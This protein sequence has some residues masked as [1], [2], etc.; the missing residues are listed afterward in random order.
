LNEA[1]RPGLLDRAVGLLASA[2][3][4]VGLNGTRLRWR[5][6][7]RRRDL[8]EAGMQA[9]MTVRSARVRYKMCPAC[10]ALVPRETSS[11]TECGAG[12]SRVRAPGVGRALSNVIPGATAATGLLVLLNGVCFLVMLAV[13]FAIPGRETGGLFGFDPGTLLRYGSGFSLLT[14]G[15]GEWWR[16]VTPIF[17][18]GGLLHFAMNT[19]VL[20]QLGPLVEEEY[21]TERFA[22][23]YL[24]TGIASTFG[25]QAFRVVNMVGASGA[26]C[27]LLGLM[28]VHGIRRGGAYGNAIRNVMIQNTLLMLVISF[29]PGIDFVAHLSGFLVGFVLGWVVPYGA[30]RNRVSAFL[31]DLAPIAGVVLIVWAFWRMAVEGAGSALLVLGR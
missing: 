20:L 31:W 15:N 14:F 24:V 4:A 23:I 16:L 18:H 30:I 13:P 3:D 21:G 25:S 7:Q 1:H 12:L 5:W 27:G 9:E 22:T 28:L 11:C 6:N 10:R 17:L 2:M 8:G 19:M 29:L 26:L